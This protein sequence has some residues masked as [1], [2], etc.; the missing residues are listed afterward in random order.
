M[1]EDLD[2]DVKAWRDHTSDVIR[3]RLATYKT[4]SEGNIYKEGIILTITDEMFRTVAE[5]M[6]YPY[7]SLTNAERWVEPPKPINR[8]DAINKEEENNGKED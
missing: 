2:L 4:D 7:Q 8:W 5:G 6:Q 3:V 1:A